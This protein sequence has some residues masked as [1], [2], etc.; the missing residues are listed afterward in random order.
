MLYL[1]GTLNALLSV[2]SESIKNYEK[3]IFLFCFFMKWNL[4]WSSSIL[5]FLADGHA[6]MQNTFPA[7]D[8]FFSTRKGR[9][10]P[11]SYLRDN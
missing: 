8:Y 7:L 10:N 9:P 1:N 2:T 4:F 11:E 3:K 5:V 6:E